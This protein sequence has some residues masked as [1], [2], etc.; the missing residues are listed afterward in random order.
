VL[1]P[2]TSSSY[3]DLSDISVEFEKSY[4]EWSGPTGLSGLKSASVPASKV[5]VVMYSASDSVLDT[6]VQQTEGVADYVFITSDSQAEAYEGFS[7]IFADMVAS[8]DK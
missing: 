1:N 5:A 6:V 7:P 3:T 2:G 4:A 8:L